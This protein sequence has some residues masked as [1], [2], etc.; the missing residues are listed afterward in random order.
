MAVETYDAKF[1]YMIICH[2]MLK[3]MV[4]QCKIAHLVDIN[5][6]I[7]CMPRVDTPTSLRPFNLP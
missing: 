1:S 6:D 3:R 2:R 7:W 4:G 5:Y